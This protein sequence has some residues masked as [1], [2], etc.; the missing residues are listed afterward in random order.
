[1]NNVVLPTM[2]FVLPFVLSLLVGLTLLVTGVV[3]IIKVKN[4]IVGSLV[5]GFGLLAT[6]LP[7]G[8]FLLYTITRIH[9]I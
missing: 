4:K 1:M 7:I 2:F 9:S 5:T 3:L 8:I 6:M